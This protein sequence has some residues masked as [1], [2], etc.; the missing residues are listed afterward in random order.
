[1]KVFAFG[2]NIPHGQLGLGNNEVNARVPT[3]VKS[4]EGHEIEHI[5]SSSCH[6]FAVTAG[7]SL[8]LSAGSGPLGRAKKKRFHFNAVD[9][10]QSYIIRGASA[11]SSSS[12]NQDAFSIVQAQ[13][14]RAFSWGVNLKGQLGL[15]HR[16]PDIDKPKHVSS[17][18]E[19]VV[20]ME[21]GAAHTIC[22]THGCAVLTFG[23][24]KNGQL[25]QGDFVS[26]PIPRQVPGL[27]NRPVTEVCAGEKHCL[28]LTVG[29][30]AFAWG[31]NDCGQLGIGQEKSVK[32]V[33]RP[34]QITGLRVAKPE[35]IACGFS[36]SFAICA[37]GAKLLGWGNNLRGQLGLS[38]TENQFL[39]TLILDK[40]GC[41]IAH[42]AA[43]KEHSLALFADH[44]LYGFGSNAVGQLGL[45]NAR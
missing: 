20:H 38:S 6:T 45:P 3:L 35:H 16:N 24:N 42:I 22:L 28:V 11:S 25:G 27:Q 33:A 9:A 19:D 13:D 18:E 32:E 15:G 5:S 4:L 31:R 36:H 29:G 14:G 34:V 1:M 23:A 21:S 41:K 10:F 30:L 7:S 43:G 37:G 44:K 26:S 39:P 40:P 8:L 17:I 2:L 12:A